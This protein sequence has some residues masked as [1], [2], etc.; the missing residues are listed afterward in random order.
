MARF[1]RGPVTVRSA[2]AVIVTSTAVVVLVSG[3]VMR[4]LDHRE[5]HNVF[6]GM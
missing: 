3:V 4:A 6:I 2:A 5:Y 1:L